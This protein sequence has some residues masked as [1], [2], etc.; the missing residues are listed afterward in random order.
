M[1]WGRSGQDREDAGD[2]GTGS[3]SSSSRFAQWVVQAEPFI[4]P[5]D[6]S[7]RASHGEL[8]LSDRMSV[9]AGRGSTAGMT[10]APSAS[11]LS[12]S[13]S[14]L[15]LSAP[16]YKP[17]SMLA[18]TSGAEAADAQPDLVHDASA[19]K[20]QQSSAGRHQSSIIAPGMFS[21]NEAIQKD[22]QATSMSNRARK[23]L[24]R[25]AVGG[26]NSST[27][28]GFA[29]QDVTSKS[30]SASAASTERQSKRNSGR[31]GG[32]GTSGSEI[33][34]TA[35]PASPSGVTSLRTHSSS[36]RREADGSGGGR[37]KED[38]DTVGSHAGGSSTK[39]SPVRSSAASKVG[40]SNVGNAFVLTGDF[41]SPNAVKAA[42][43]ERRMER[44]ATQ[45][46]LKKE[47]IDVMVQQRRRELGD[48]LCGKLARRENSD[49]SSGKQD[50]TPT[51]DEKDELERRG[52]DAQLASKL[53]EKEDEEAEEKE[54]QR[55]IFEEQQRYA[56]IARKH[57]LLL[58]ALERNARRHTRRQ[59][60][61][62][63]APL[64][65]PSSISDASSSPID[66]G[67]RDASLKK[68]SGFVRKLSK[69]NTLGDDGCRQLIG[70]SYNLNLS[71]YVTEMAAAVA[72]AGK[73]M[74]ATTEAQIDACALLCS[75]LQVQYPEFAPALVPILA[76]S[77]SSKGSLR[78]LCELVCLGVVPADSASGLLLPALK[79]LVK[80]EC[81]GLDDRVSHVS[82][83]S[84]VA[85]AHAIEF[86]NERTSLME[87][88]QAQ[89]DILAYLAEEQVQRED[90]SCWAATSHTD[91]AS[92]F[93][94]L[95]DILPSA[96]VKHGLRSLLA[97]Y[98]IQVEEQWLKEAVDTSMKAEADFY[99]AQT[100]NDG[101][102]ADAMPLERSRRAV[103]RML[104]CATHL[105]HALGMN[106]PQM[107][108]HSSGAN[109][110]GRTFPLNLVENSTT[111]YSSPLS[112][113][114]S[115]G[116]SSSTSALNPSGTSCAP[117]SVFDSSERAFYEDIPDLK[118]LFASKDVRIGDGDLVSASAALGRSLEAVNTGSVQDD[119][120]IA[121]SEAEAETP[122][123]T[124]ERTTMP[125][126][127]NSAANTNP[128]SS[129]KAA[130]L[131]DAD[132]KA[133][134]TGRA[135]S[136]M[137]SSGSS[138][139]KSSKSSKPGKAEKN[140]LE[141]LLNRLPSCKTVNEIDNAAAAFAVIGSKTGAR[142][143]AK[144]LVGS[145]PP[146][147]LNV[148]PLYAR[149]V[150]E[151]APLFPELVSGLV[152]ALEEEFRATVS[153]KDQD[154]KALMLRVRNARF[155]GEMVNFR[156][157]APLS[158]YFELLNLCLV[159]F[160][161]HNVDVACH[162]IETSGKYLL[163]ASET[164][165]RMGNMLD[166]F[167]RVQALKNLDIRHSTMV[168]AA[169]F[170][171]R[172]RTAALARQQQK[173]ALDP[174]QEYARQ[175]LYSDFDSRGPGKDRQALLRQLLRLPWNDA[176]FEAFMIDQVLCAE[177]LRAPSLPKLVGLL[178]S[179]SGAASGTGPVTAS[180]GSVYPGFTI[181]LIDM[182]CESIRFHLQRPPLL[183]GGMRQRRYAE[184]L[185]LAELCSAGVIESK[186]LFEVLFALIAYGLDPSNHHFNAWDPPGDFFRVYQVCAILCTCSTVALLSSPAGH[187]AAPS[188]GR[189]GARRRLSIFLVFFELYLWQKARQ[190]C[191]MKS[192]QRNKPQHGV[193][194][195]L[196]ALHVTQ[197]A[198]DSLAPT[199]I[200][201]NYKRP[202]SYEDAVR[203]VSL[204]VMQNVNMNS[205]LSTPTEQ[206]QQQ[207]LQTY[208][209][210][211]LKVNGSTA[212]ALREWLITGAVESG[213]N[214]ASLASEP[215]E[216][217]YSAFG[218]DPVRARDSAAVTPMSSSPEPGEQLDEQANEE[219]EEN[220][221]GSEA[222]DEQPVVGVVIEGDASMTD[223]SD[224]SQ[225][226]SEDDDVDS[227]DSI[228][229]G[230]DEDEGKD[231][232]MEDEDE[233]ELVYATEKFEISAEGQEQ[234][235][236]ELAAY[237][238]ENI[239]AARQAKSSVSVQRMSVPLYGLGRKREFGSGSTQ[240]TD[241][242]HALPSPSATNPASNDD[243]QPDTIPFRMLVRKGAK[244]QA[245]ELAIP[246]NSSLATSVLE[247]DAHE[248]A[249]QLEMKRLVLSSK[250][251]NSEESDNTTLPVA[252]A[253]RDPRDDEPDAH[254][255]KFSGLFKPKSGGRS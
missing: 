28:K 180:I 205:S 21:M 159:D 217:G 236:R 209:P 244:S 146:S 98:M 162:L 214:V 246:R 119:G 31:K 122:S 111:F 226:Q 68:C 185:L 161:H 92:S 145:V 15:S 75:E 10:G 74:K 163:R 57:D 37:K 67:S 186:L 60:H 35:A 218:A 126:P 169:Y 125:T 191:E 47:E 17:L 215:T 141:Q 78:L 108:I 36:R 106:P 71:R 149:F 87:L 200:L 166:T 224:E 18:A 240:T 72:D 211:Y 160:A 198:L 83:V 153:K 150:A 94:W 219:D 252:L 243:A 132:A 46:G 63:A 32:K 100:R 168:E 24:Q 88:Q 43:A 20:G 56:E 216:N 90:P 109:A 23:K 206:Q 237:L 197:D 235:D 165:F 19:R 247:S 207:Q 152:A 190:E 195:P 127:A 148:V 242:A 50:K 65:A 144:L 187:G 89:R 84:S 80:D 113:S 212:A 188:Q 131:P 138:G 91:V 64:E 175:L 120:T 139:T 204:V 228:S 251:L 7:G 9:H 223:T 107:Q 5:G 164:A 194:I 86:F 4:P 114:S 181:G 230:K 176:Q 104:T 229:E 227:E 62:G 6:A 3:S 241:T 76:K 26:Q 48:D 184:M 99:A 133:L 254:L 156:V 140:P 173:R 245:K 30:D 182:L 54:R 8:G 85:A 250:T 95:D 33:L 192:E 231:D 115:G 222:L 158:L 42:K 193:V 248:R 130:V 97:N 174:L 253:S 51:S 234:F 38:R 58:H 221:S 11:L 101:S 121:L 82:I 177:R 123:P 59:I 61:T 170:G 81:T 66:C 13:V 134:V 52:R 210:Y 147:K 135:I 73:L 151:L 55:I 167:W 49:R 112:V 53:K 105:A 137:E 183:L 208:L 124:A 34:S 157:F 202:T 172:P 1:Q 201:K 171:C 189:G 249:A 41:K 70:E 45:R 79:A 143:M 69:L 220:L 213:G 25:E 102:V 178:F 255:V 179:T 12:A 118:K 16:E 142:K 77:A 232:N 136:T 225:K 128:L 203:Q 2:A 22:A 239:S 14:G 93:R 116:F 27:R 39:E 196:D 199:G 155:I 110:Q 44:K 117:N 154:D 103:D 96:Q 29:R 129:E 233:E 238:Q 40:T